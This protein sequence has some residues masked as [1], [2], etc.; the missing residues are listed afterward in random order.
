MDNL[1]YCNIKFLGGIKMRSFKPY[2]KWI[3][4]NTKFDNVEVGEYYSFK[5]YYKW[6][7]FNTRS[8]RL[9]LIEGYMV[10]NLIING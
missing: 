8:S 3:I 10:L 1:Q 5:P 2:Y 4:F 7:I 9:K 6:I